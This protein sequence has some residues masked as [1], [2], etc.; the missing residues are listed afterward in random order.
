M[1]HFSGDDLIF[2]K[3]NGKILSGGYS[4]DSI[5]L[6]NN[7]S[8]MTTLNT[9][10][11]GGGKNVSSSF[12]NLAVPA[13]LLYLHNSNSKT[14]NN[15]NNTNE[16]N[17]EYRDHVTMDD[18]LHD[19]LFKLAEVNKP[20]KKRSIKNKKSIKETKSKKK[21]RKNVNDEHE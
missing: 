13:G 6:K 17:N 14:N 5:L 12:E 3:E 18:D 16:F 10:Q 8:P 1:T 7:I 4:I 9:N 19:K 15:N 21:S 20:K 11:M 2:Y